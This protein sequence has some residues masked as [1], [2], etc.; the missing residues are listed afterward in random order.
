MTNI[1]NIKNM[2]VSASE[3]VIVTAEAV[4]ARI[5]NGEFDEYIKTEIN[6]LIDE[7]IESEVKNESI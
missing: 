6:K 3:A 1:E 7:Q 5:L 4:K 2:L